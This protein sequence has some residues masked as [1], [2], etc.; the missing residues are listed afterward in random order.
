MNI[1]AALDNLHPSIAPDT[2]TI[3]VGGELIHAGPCADERFNIMSVTKAATCT[4][5]GHLVTQGKCTL[6][7]PVAKWIDGFDDRYPAVTLRHLL[8][9]TSGYNAKGGTYGVDECSDGA[10]DFLDAADPVFDPGTMWHYHDDALRL[11]TV[12]L[13]NIGGESLDAMLRKIVPTFT[14][15]E[16]IDYHGNGRGNDAGSGILTSARALS[17]FGR[18]WCAGASGVDPV[19]VADATRPQ[20]AHLPEYRGPL[21]RGLG[22]SDGGAAM[23]YLWRS[24]SN[25]CFPALPPDAFWI[26]GWNH[27]RLFVVPSKQL[28]VTR[29]GADGYIDNTIGKWDAFFAALLN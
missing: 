5:A 16:W 12:A 11:L 15:F 3:V 8:T 26:S 10:I 27:N 14:D 18:Y 7:D 17:D 19:F 13:P 24:N 28:V 21:Y 9:M 29:T 20:S 6:D 22:G 2:V 25:G 1:P 23:G 4:V